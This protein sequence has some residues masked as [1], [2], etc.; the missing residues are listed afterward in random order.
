LHSGLGKEERRGEYFFLKEVQFLLVDCN[1][2]PLFFPFLLHF[3][4][5]HSLVRLGKREEREKKKQENQ[6]NGKREG[7]K[8]RKKSKKA[9]ATI[10]AERSSQSTK[11]KRY[12]VVLRGGYRRETTGS[13][14]E[15]KKKRKRQEQT[16]H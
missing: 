13:K 11:Q 6:K 15:G 7:N 2:Q 4:V 5:H 9:N 14:G 1:H 8:K 3:Q 10:F 12:S 16:K